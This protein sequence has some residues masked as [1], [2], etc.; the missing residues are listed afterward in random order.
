M[1]FKP[2]NA[3]EVA[4]LKFRDFF[5]RHPESTE[6][7]IYV[8]QTLTDAEATWLAQQL[9]LTLVQRQPLGYLHVER[10]PG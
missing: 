4:A 7:A 9:Q 2:S 10:Q 6:V 3:A 8:G 1:K 5:A